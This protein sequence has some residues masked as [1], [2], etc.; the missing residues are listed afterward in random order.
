MP[1]C[2]SVTP[3]LG[4]PCGRD[5]HSELVACKASGTSDGV[6]WTLTW[7]RPGHTRE[8]VRADGLPWDDESPAPVLGSTGW[9]GE[10]VRLS[11]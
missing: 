2:T 1:K 5:P 4:I 8:D 9:P 11:G 6:H 10:A 7:W 3:V